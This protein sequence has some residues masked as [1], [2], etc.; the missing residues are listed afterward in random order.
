MML[1]AIAFVTMLRRS[2]PAVHR[3]QRMVLRASSQLSASPTGSTLV[4]EAVA[5]CGLNSLMYTD[6]KLSWSHAP[7]TLSPYAYP[8]EGFEYAQRI[9]PLINT[10]IDNI[11]RD[12]EFLVSVLE[13]VAASDPFVQRLLDLYREVPE[14]VV[15]SGIAL[16]IH[17]SDYMLNN[18][19]PSSSSS[20]SSSSTQVPLQIEINTIASSFGCLSSKVGDLHRHLLSRHFGS[21]DLEAVLRATELPEMPEGGPGC[22]EG[23]MPYNPTIRMLATSLALSHFLSG[24][25]SSVIVFV[26][27]PNERN[28]ADQRL[29]EAELWSTHGLKVEFLTLEQ[30]DA[31]CSLGAGGSL[32]LAPATATLA[33]ILPSSSSFSPSAEAPSP[34]SVVY[35]RAGYSPDDYPGEQQWRARGLIERSAAVKCPNVGYQLAGTKKVQQV[36]CESGVLEKFLPNVDDA[37]LVRRCFAAQYPLGEGASPAAQQAA[38]A[39]EK[40]GSQWVV[41]PQREGGGNNYY[42]AELSAFLR[43]NQGS[44]VLS[45]Y[46]LMQRIFPKAQKAAFL[47]SGQVQ[48]LDSI[49]ELGVYGTFLGDGGAEPVLNECA[50]YLLRTKPVGVDEGGVATGFSVLNSV[51]LL[52]EEDV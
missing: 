45:S 27:Q 22:A 37:A 2:V 20:S 21:P 35:F 9:Q 8:R 4:Q 6:G 17:R 18:A 32:L 43:E 42:G 25:R 12:R 5:W 52:D 39:A 7:V 10:L 40:D 16:G 41:K 44:P 30:V 38:A 51:V 26:V 31:R 36:L 48:V 34:V 50:G 19:A 33:S 24:D 28:Q 1:R 11:A 14:A 29:L 46:V 3:S 23:L 47:R 13:S 15:R 49:S